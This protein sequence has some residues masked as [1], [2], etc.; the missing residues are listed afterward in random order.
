M[1]LTNL[2]RAILLVSSVVGLMT[3]YEPRDAIFVA[4]LV[5]VVTVA[6]TAAD[7]AEALLVDYFN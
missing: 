3:F 1:L 6:Q 5:L 4:L 2:I 7:V